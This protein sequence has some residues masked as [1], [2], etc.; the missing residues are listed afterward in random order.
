MRW[1]RHC[2]ALLR[3]TTDD[4]ADGEIVW[5]W[6]P[7]AG[8]KLVDASRVMR[9]T[10]ANKPGTPGR[11]RISRNTIA[12]GRPDDPPTPVVLPRAFCCTRT[13]GAAGTR[14]SLRPL[15]F[16]GERVSHNSGASRREN[17]KS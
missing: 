15:F 3:K 14:S 8:A 10:V 6:R 12:Q 9:V 1:T 17:A 4:A 11:S 13:M 2:Q 5:S 7:D 16:R